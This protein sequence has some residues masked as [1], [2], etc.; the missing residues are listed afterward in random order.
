VISPV[1]QHDATGCAAAAAA[2]AAAAETPGK[3]LTYALAS[4][5][6]L[7]IAEPRHAAVVARTGTVGLHTVAAAAAAAVKS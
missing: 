6:M 4:L 5:L 2:A 7:A 1:Q 3:T